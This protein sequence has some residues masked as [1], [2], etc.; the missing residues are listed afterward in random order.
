[1]QNVIVSNVNELENAVNSWVAKGYSITNK[2]ASAAMLVKKKEFSIP[3]A[4]IGFLL[5]IIGLIIYC[6]VY[7]MQTDKVVSIKVQ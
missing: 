5:C 2:T 7:S 4:I 3:F 1:M 6:V